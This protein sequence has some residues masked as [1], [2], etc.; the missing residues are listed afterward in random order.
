MVQYTVEYTTR[1]ERNVAITDAQ[2]QGH[3]MIHDNF[4]TGVVKQHSLVFEDDPVSLIP[5]P[6]ADELEL[7]ALKTSLRTTPSLKD[8]VRFM[9]LEGRLG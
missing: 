2:G 1:D 8:I 3:Q 5:P 9:E 7:E 4:D 6:T